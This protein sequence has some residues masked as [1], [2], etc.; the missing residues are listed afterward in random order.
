[1]HRLKYVEENALGRATYG[2]L[3]YEPEGTKL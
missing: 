3:F 2:K 1:M